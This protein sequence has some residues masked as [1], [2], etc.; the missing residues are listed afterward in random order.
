MSIT[1]FQKGVSLSILIHAVLFTLFFLYHWNYIP[2]AASSEIEV[3]SVEPTGDDVFSN[4]EGT[5]TDIPF[6]LPKFGQ[7]VSKEN[8]NPR[9]SPTSPT[10][11]T[12]QMRMN[13]MR[14]EAP[15]DL[16]RSQ[17]RVIAGNPRG[18][19]NS[20]YQGPIPRMNAKPL[21][22]S[23][24]SYNEKIRG[25]SP[26]YLEGDI[27]ESSVVYKKIPEYPKG[28][29]KNAQVVLQFSVFPNGKVDPNSVIVIKKAD[30]KLDVLSV[31]SLQ[32]WKFTPFVGKQIRKG[33]ITFIYQ[34][35]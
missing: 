19:V 13:V 10:S 34:I 29:Q 26:F 23:L 7:D 5:Q 11:N 8:N 1:P 32:E 33:K 6:V 35:K 2:G 27:Q 24:D 14:S 22:K 20:D 21:V 12:E 30:P 18:S 4:P 16:G 15:V 28:L 9:F 25:N 3:I 31:E 17:S